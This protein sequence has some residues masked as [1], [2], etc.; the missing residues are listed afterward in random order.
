MLFGERQQIATVI[1]FDNARL[2]NTLALSV[3]LQREYENEIFIIQ[4]NV[5]LPCT[6]DAKIN[7]IAY[8]ITLFT[9]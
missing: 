5:G 4:N 1:F 7:K 9:K 6:I 8:I 3:E 2:G